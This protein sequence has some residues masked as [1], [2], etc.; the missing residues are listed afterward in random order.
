MSDNLGWTRDDVE[1]ITIDAS[2][3]VERNFHEKDNLDDC[4]FIVDESNNEETTRMSTPRISS[5]IV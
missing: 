3:I 4:E 2:I 5:V 1:G